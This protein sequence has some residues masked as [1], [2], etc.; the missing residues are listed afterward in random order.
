MRSAGTLI[1]HAADCHGQSLLDHARAAARATM[2]FQYLGFNP[3]VRKERTATNTIKQ[4]VWL[5]IEDPN[6]HHILC[7]AFP[8]AIKPN[9]KS[10][11]KRLPFGTNFSTILVE[12]FSWIWNDLGRWRLLSS[13]ILLFASA[14]KWI[15]NKCFFGSFWGCVPVQ[16][17]LHLHFVRGFP[18]LPKQK[19]APAHQ[20]K[21]YSLKFDEISVAV[22]PA[23]GHHGRHCSSVP[24][25]PHF[26]WPA[27]YALTL[28]CQF[29]WRA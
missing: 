26:S 15:E 16:V 21:L 10:I 8:E 2:T 27:Q 17:S 4:H 14:K 19:W 20:R 28:Q 9:K 29:A 12:F 1:Y 24:L 7:F 18:K 5:P 13:L 11:S 22:T 6:C 23:T 25:F 3:C